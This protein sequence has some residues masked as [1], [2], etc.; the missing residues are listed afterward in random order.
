MVEARRRSRDVG[1]PRSPGCR[2]SSGP[3]RTRWATRARA[4]VAGTGVGCA[5]SPSP[6][7]RVR[8]HATVHRR[9]ARGNAAASDDD[10]EDGGAVDGLGS[11]R[12][13]PPRRQAPASPWRA[14]DP[15][16]CVPRARVRRAAR[17]AGPERGPARRGPGPRST[18]VAWSLSSA[19]S[20]RLRRQE[21]DPAEPAVAVNDPVDR[22]AP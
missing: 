16:R 7:R 14:A 11:G 8:E 4:W 9:S 2:M 10:G 18:G 5:G 3:S 15:R 21:A 20:G 19:A 6:V 12:M 22:P 13:T 1:D 17:R